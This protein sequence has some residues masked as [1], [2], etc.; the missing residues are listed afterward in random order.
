MPSLKEQIKNEQIAALKNREED[1]LSVLRFLNSAIKNAEI[2]KQKE[3]SDA[4]VQEVIAR[5]V[6]QSQDA[7]KDFEKG[8]RADLVENTNREINLL[9]NYLPAQLSAEEAETA[10]KKILTDNG[11]LENKDVGKAIGLV[12]KEL[13]G[14]ADG[15]LVRQLVEKIL[16]A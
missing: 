12:M 4:E 15:N 6:N 7:L 2:E 5:Q 13:K 10:V 9:K 14:K 11:L 3:L 8:G 16:T 1:K